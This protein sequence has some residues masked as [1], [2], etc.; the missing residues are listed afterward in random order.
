[1]DNVYPLFFYGD[2]FGFLCVPVCVYRQVL[3]LGLELGFFCLFFVFL[4]RGLN[5]SIGL[6]KKGTKV[7]NCSTWPKTVEPLRW[8]FH[9]NVK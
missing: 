3:E 6:S 5:S 7:I 4:N 2:I 9:L 8:K 1:M